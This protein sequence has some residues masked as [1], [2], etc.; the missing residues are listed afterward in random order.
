MSQQPARG[1]QPDNGDF[2][3][4]QR[5]D[6]PVAPS[7]TAQ[8]EFFDFL[9]SGSDMKYSDLKELAAKQEPLPPFALKGVKMTI[10]V[11]AD[12]TVVR[13]Q[14]T[15]NVVGIIPG[16]DAKLKDSYVAFGAHYDH[17]GYSQTAG[18]TRI[19]RRRRRR[20]RCTGQT[21]ETPQAWRQHQQRSRR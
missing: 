7:L 16:T 1:A 2:T 13:T 15:H 9:F 5:Y 4:V 17:I 18:A 19:R 3:T 21:R 14:L 12:Y 11:D 8:D 6:L 20:R 10:N